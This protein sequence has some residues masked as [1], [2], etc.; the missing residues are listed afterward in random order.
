MLDRFTDRAR[1]TLQLAKNEAER[2]RSDCIGTEHI[3][4]GL[5]LEGT[6]VGAD[7]LMGEFKLGVESVRKS[8]ISNA[9]KEST[10]GP[11]PFTSASKRI[12]ER[13][14]TEAGNGHVGTEHILLSLAM[15]TDSVAARLLESL[16]I[17]PE[18]IRRSIRDY[19][20]SEKNEKN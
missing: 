11:L 4:I 15:E 19:L 9:K 13:A 12:I 17:K 8:M 10:P 6:G 7:I 3:L 16:G 18:S 20:R 5:L 2:L 1:K 14:A